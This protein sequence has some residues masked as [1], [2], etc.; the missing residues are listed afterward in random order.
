MAEQRETADL[1]GP[2]PASAFA[3]SV[4]WT[5]TLVTDTETI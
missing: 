4:T 5:S 1:R 2:Q 3:V